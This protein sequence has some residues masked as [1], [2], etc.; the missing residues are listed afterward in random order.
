VAELT[1]LQ[2]RRF[3][4][5]IGGT[6]VAALPKL[7]TFLTTCVISQF[8]IIQPVADPG[9]DNGGPRGEHG[10]RAY[11]GVCGIAPVRFRGKAHTVHSCTVEKYKKQVARIL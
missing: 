8:L 11:K 10:M 1:S 4:K 3:A 2:G 7:I 6:D 9:I 5:N